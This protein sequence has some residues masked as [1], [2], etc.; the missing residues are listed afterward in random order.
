MYNSL[1]VSTLAR[2]RS[3][4]LQLPLERQEEECDPNSQ[5]PLWLIPVLDTMMGGPGRQLVADCGAMKKRGA[6]K[7]LGEDR[8]NDQRSNPGT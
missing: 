1:H 4:K 6:V 2:Q 8:T 7:S 3:H 5:Q